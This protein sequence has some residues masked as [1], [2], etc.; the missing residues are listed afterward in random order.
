MASPAPAVKPRGSLS[1]QPNAAAA[2]AGKVFGKKN[3]AAADSSR[4]PKK[5]LAGR[6]ADVA[7]TEPPASSLVAPAA[8]AHK[9]FDGSEEEEDEVED[10][11]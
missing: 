5:K 2:K 11:A 10:E 3:K 6:A 8:D 4:R 1:K 9:V 7:P